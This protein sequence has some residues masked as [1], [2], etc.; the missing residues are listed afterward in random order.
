MF[1]SRR[2]GGNTWIWWMIA[3][4][5]LGGLALGLYLAL[6]FLRGRADETPQEV[7]EVSEEVP[8]EVT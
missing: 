6:R 2:R 5:F 1:G 3:T 4:L 8:K 7:S